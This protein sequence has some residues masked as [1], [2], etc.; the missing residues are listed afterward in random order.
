MAAH[1]TG[2]FSQIWRLG[3]LRVPLNRLWNARYCLN[4]KVTSTYD[5]VMTYGLSVV[6]F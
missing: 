1:Y 3:L 2:F 4:I 5:W 6:H